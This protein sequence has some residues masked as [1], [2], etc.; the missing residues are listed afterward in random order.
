MIQRLT[1]LSLLTFLGLTTALAQTGNIK[2]NI[3]DENG[4]P[5][6]AVTVYIKE[7]NKG[8]TSDFEGNYDLTNIPAGTYHILF[9]FVGYKE[10]VKTVQA[11]NG[12]VSLP[13]I[14]LEQTNEMIEEVVVVGYGTTLQ[15]DVTG[16]IARVKAE[17]LENVVTPSF[18]QSIQGRAAGV[19]ITSANGVAGAPVK[20]NIRGSNSISAGSEPLYVIDGIPMTS[21]SFDPGSLGSGS[22]ALTDLNPDDIESIEILKD[23][24]ATAI[25]GSRGANG[26]VLITTKKGKVGKTKFNVSYYSGAIEATRKLDLLNATEMLAL[27]NRARAEAGKDPETATTVLANVNNGDQWTR[28][29]AD[30]FALL[31]GTNWV[32]QMIRTGNIHNL[33]VNATG[34]SE[35]LLFYYGG[36][37]RK[38]EGFLVGNDYE[39]VNGRI[40]LEN[41]ASERLKIGMTVGLTFSENGRVRTGDAG[42][43]GWAQQMMPYIPVYDENGDLFNPAGNPLWYIENQTFT[44]NGFRSLSNIY[45]DYK[46]LDK[47][48]FRSEFG[49]DYFNQV[50]FEFNPRNPFDPNSSAS[51]WD[52]RTNV[53]NWTTNNFFTFSDTVGENSVVDALL[54][55]AV[56]NSYTVGVGLNGYNFVN[57]FLQN[58]GTA[59]SDNQGGYAYET[60]Y[61]FVSYFTRLNYKLKDKY[62]FSFSLRNDG[63]SRFGSNSRYGWFPAISGGWILSDEDFLKESKKI[64]FL[65]LRASYG[66]AGNAEI[67]DFASLGYYVPTNGYAGQN[68]TAPA[69][70]PNQDLTW[71]KSKQF[72]VTLDY[73]F[74]NNRIYGNLTYYSKKSYDLLMFL[75]LPTSSGFPGIWQN[76]GALQNSGVEFTLST[77]NLSKKLM[78]STDFN[79]A[80][81][82]NRVVDVSGLP[83]DAFESGQPGEGRV[84]IGESAGIHYVVRS[85]GVQE[86]NGQLTA[87]NVDGTIQADQDGN[88]VM[89]DVNAGT[90]LY[91]DLNGNHMTFANPTGDFYGDN[92]VAVGNPVPK[93][94]GGMTNNFKYKNFDLNILLSFVYGNTIYDD[95]AKSQIG[96]Y[97]SVNQ[98]NE[99]ENS[100]NADNSSSTIPS[101]NQYV[102][103][104]NS[105]RWIYDASYIRLRSLS[106]GYS[107]SKKKCNK[108]KIQSAR[109]FVNG[110][111]L[112][113]LTKFPGW[114]P[115]VLR[116]VEPNS[117]AGNVSFAGP[118]YQT[119]QARM[120][121]AGIKLGF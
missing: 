31:G 19:Q 81:N 109:I 119:P 113:I 71:E 118:S 44:S 117:Q 6:F 28:A 74:V 94:I 36:T 96:L 24:A 52:R 9:R 105:D 12:T 42:G 21:G 84:V 102:T 64:E 111:N 49:Y 3:L 112:F 67:G 120:V 48:K 79:I 82:R 5:A 103:G 92:R 53:K 16:S 7:L 83:P 101:L 38:E 14:E 108:L 69:Q 30:S 73:A 70:L 86:T 62:L 56:Q 60:G 27:R 121:T 76:V 39:R 45:L 68:G 51:S 4:E 33:S 59:S 88:P 55:M 18:E 99:I 66:F 54:G 104:V 35:N 93:F 34:G 95:P 100:W 23:A 90:E 110:S 107:L 63:S 15:R 87:Y 91:Y 97:K 58:P 40:N 61:G 17:D 106:L 115:E 22:N 11:T 29:M 32:D 85:A 46:V 114:D 1:L 57:D 26:V 77:K 50:E 41:K 98:R 65:K 72:D 89:N 43:L 20:V 25:Y 2:G 75:A 8:V 10:I 116:N 37:Y 13:V 80:F 47:V 78:W